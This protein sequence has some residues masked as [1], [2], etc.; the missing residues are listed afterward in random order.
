MQ[1]IR[2]VFGVMGAWMLMAS[3]QAQAATPVVIGCDKASSKITLTSSAV[4][5]PTCTYTG[6]V[7]ITASN[8]ELDCRGALIQD[9]TGSGSRGILITSD[10]SVPLANVTVRNCEISGFT[11]TIRVSRQGFKT[12]TEGHE[13]DVT[14]SNIQLLDSYLHNSRGSGIFVDGY[15]TGVTIQGMQIEEA[16]SVGIYL[17]AGSKDS[18]VQ[19]NIIHHN[20]YGDVDPNGTPYEYGNV[21]AY[22]VS[23]G[24]EGIA[25]DGSRNNVIENNVISGNS[26]GGIFLY[27]NCGEDYTSNPN[28]WWTRR[29]GADGN[30]I[31]NNHIEQEDNGVWIGSRMAE[32][33][34]FMDCSDPTYVSVG[35]WYI[36]EDFAANN[37]VE[38]NEFVNVTYG[39]RVEDNGASVLSN[40]F[41]DVDSTHQAVVVGTLFR[42]KYLDEPVTDTIITNNDALIAGN[43]KPY[44]WIHDHV[45]TTFSNNS[46]NG[47][48]APLV[49][50]DQPKL[51][52]HLFTEK[53]WIER[54]PAR[55]APG[56][57]ARRGKLKPSIGRDSGDHF[58]RL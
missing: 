6:G 39:V 45:N 51:H 27:K 34:Y 3:V 16:G 14:Y 48:P 22:Y 8:V 26:A 7:E 15:V 47:V 9:V 46:A 30:T 56:N 1:A 29:Y 41:T 53:I 32:N 55:S 42:T 10:V 50:G 11:N 5:D 36:F 25:V 40:S 49:H 58:G 57:K 23:T 31:R 2:V 18:V 19:D 54:T 17:E 4:L 43:E 44:Q 20:G 38:G 52:I 12:L 24:R 21:T 35:L 28:G 33:Q 13:Y 37:V